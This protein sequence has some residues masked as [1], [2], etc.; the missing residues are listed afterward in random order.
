MAEYRLS[1]AAQRDIDEIFD[2]TAERWGLPQALHYIDLIEA[3]CAGIAEAPHQSQDCASIRPGYRRR[4][5]E[6]HAI[7]FRRTDY[8][9]AIVRVLHQRMDRTRHL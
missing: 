8:G 2:Y 9:V 1:P 3:A 7:Y 4:I 6:Q 5:I